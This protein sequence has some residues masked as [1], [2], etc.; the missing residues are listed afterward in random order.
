[1]R[2][3]TGQLG[4]SEGRDGRKSFQL[5]QPLALPRNHEKHFVPAVEHLR[6]PDWSGDFRAELVPLQDVLRQ[7][8][9]VVEELVRIE[10]V[11][12]DVFENGTM[13]FVRA[14]LGD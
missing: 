5:G 4:W 9:L 1:M 10:G 2:E 3:I 6:N 14:R 12:P 7:A 13:K 11:V 8:L